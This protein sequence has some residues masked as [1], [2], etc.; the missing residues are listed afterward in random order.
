MYGVITQKLG[1][2][3]FMPFF[4]SLNQDLKQHNFVIQG[5]P[6]LVDN[7]LYTGISGIS[8]LVNVS[9]GLL[10]FGTNDFEI[11]LECKLL[12]FNNVLIDCFSSAGNGGFNTRG[13]QLFVY[14]DGRLSFYQ[15]N[16]PLLELVTDSAVLTTNEWYQIKV[17]RISNILSIFV[18]NSVVKTGLVSDNF[19]QAF[20]VIGYQLI[21]N[22][23]GQ[24]QTR[25]YIR[26]VYARHL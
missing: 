8:G 11:G 17:R 19:Q 18:N 24:Y 21:N 23:N 3:L 5:S 12:S 13:W 2:T 10:A 9:D 1:H 15:L 16:T 26:N 6:T 14:S 22:G 20:S 4:A 25:G 7:A